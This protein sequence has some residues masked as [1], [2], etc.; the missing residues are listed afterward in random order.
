MI[1]K[2][3][4]DQIFSATRVE[5]VIGD[6]V[7]LKKS[8]SNY[9]ALSPFT[10]ERTPSFMISPTKQIWKDFSSGKGGNAISF[11]MELEQF[12]Y[13]EALRYLAKKYNIEIEEDYQGDPEKYKEEKR[14][15]ESLY[16]IQEVAN[17]YFQEQLWETE[18]GKNI[19]LSYFKERGFTE[20]SIKKFQLGYS[21]EKRDAFTSFALD[22]GYSKEILEESGLSIFRENFQVDRFRE[23]VMFPIFSYSGRVLGFGG[24]I[25]SQNKKTAKYLNSPETE[26]YHKSKILYGLFQ[27]K[28]EIV[29]NDVCYL[30]EGYT[31][32]ISFHQNGVG[33]VVSSSGTALTQ[34]Q[35][36]LIKRLTKNV[37]LLF[38]ADPAGIKAS[39][40]SIDMILGEDMN[41]RVALFPE[42]ED[43]DSF[44]R[45]HSQ[46]ELLKFLQNNA[47]DF[48]Q[49]KT[50]LLMPEVG[51]DPAKKAEVIREILKSVSQVQDS[52]QRELYVQSISQKMEISEASLFKDLNQIVSSE[53]RKEE[54]QQRQ[55]AKK[56]QVVESNAKLEVNPLYEVEND[57]LSILL[58]FGDRMISYKVGEEHQE[59][60]V[61]EEIIQ[62]LEV[63]E[64][65]FR[66]DLGK[67]IYEEI[68]EGYEKDELRIASHFIK[69]ADDEMQQY[70][71]NSIFEKYELSPNWSARNIYVRPIEKDIKKKVNQT[72]LNFKLLTVEEQI[73][74][75]SQLETL[76]EEAWQE[77]LKKTMHLDQVRRQLCEMLNRPM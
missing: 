54:K 32:V 4:I 63:D 20:E 72:I 6:F 47:T 16:K 60:T 76:E 28:Q 61:I 39:L 68:K 26:I 58:E 12:S 70:I 51:N 45:A 7:Q 37:T 14:Q 57:L 33:N 29:K 17:A 48:I 8:G 56:L 30:V 42:G 3:T 10:D 66:T 24:R 67:K 46:E 13:P 75:L 5:E 31:D 52:I 62:Q 18:E 36:R 44:A 19:G 49:F 1:S 34:D 41:V 40:R 65:G 15:K 77:K 43:P 22:K 64:L 21:P 59:T 11:L 71:S 23:R 35:I 9:K 74:L 53:K 50:D 27:S 55:E 38:D 69:D 73:K 2:Q 25:L